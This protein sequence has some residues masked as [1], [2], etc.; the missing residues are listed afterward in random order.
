MIIETQ[1]LNCASVITNGGAKRMMFPC[2]GFANKPF[3]AKRTQIFQAVSL[4]SV[5]L[6]TTAFSN[7][8]PLTK[9]VMFEVSINLPN[10]SRKIFPNFLAFCDKLSSETTS[11]AAI[12]TAAATGFPPKVE[13]CCPGLITF[14][15]LSFAK[16]AETG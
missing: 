6:I 9:V 3:S 10:Y 8:F 12:A 1:S 2:V 4:S 15:M 16:T 5:S 11:K 7:P 13:P 14:I